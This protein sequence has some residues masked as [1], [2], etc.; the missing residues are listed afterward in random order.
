M[1]SRNN[2]EFTYI[3]TAVDTNGPSEISAKKASKA[4][5]YDFKFTYPDGST[6]TGT[7]A[8][9]GHYGYKV[10][11]IIDTAYGSYKITAKVGNTKEASGTVK[12]SS[13]YDASTGQSYTPYDTSHNLS[14]GS[15]GLGSEYDSI[16]G[17]NGTL[18]FGLGGQYEAPES[19][20]LY[21]FTFTYN[22][23]S[24]Y[25]GTVSS[26]ASNGTT[27]NY[28]G[29]IVPTSYGDY[30]IT[31]SV[32]ATAQTAGTVYVSSYYDVTSGQT[33]TPLDT[34]KGSSDGSYGLGYEGDYIY[35]VNGTG[36]SFSSNGHEATLGSTSF[37]YQFTYNDGSY[38][39]GTVTDNGSKG[40]YVGEVID[41]FASNGPLRGNYTITGSNGVSTDASG[42]VTI[43]S[44]Y[45][46]SSGE[47]FT[48]F[49][50]QY[51]GT[52]YA[53]GTS[54]LGSEYDYTAT[55][56]NG[57]KSFGGGGGDEAKQGVT[58]YDFT[59]TFS[60]GSYYSGTVADNGSYG[61]FVGE[62]YFT[63]YGYYEVTGSSGFSTSE[64]NGAVQVTSYYD[65]NSKKSYTPYYDWQG[66]ADGSSGLTSEYDST[67]GAS[68]SQSFGEGKYEAKQSTSTSGTPQA[69]LYDF[70]FFYNNGSYYTGTVADSGKYGYS[71][72]AA[73]F[74]SYGYYFITG[75][76]GS[77]SEA[78]GTVSVTSYWDKS[79]GTSYTPYDTWKGSSDGSSGLGSESDS[80]YG[81]SG[82]QNFGDGGKYEAV[83][84]PDTLYDYKFV[85]SDGSYY[86]GTV[87]DNG[88]YGYYVGDTID[89][90]NNGASAGYYEITGNAGDV[91]TSIGGF[92]LVG[93]VTI[94]SYYDT[95]S[96]QS[97]IP[98]VTASGWV[99]GYYGLGDESSSTYG[100]NGTQTFGKGGKYEA[101]QGGTVYDYTFYYTDGSY[102]SGTVV[103]DGAYGYYVGDTMQL[104]STGYYAITGS[105]GKTSTITNGTV[106][107]SSY[108]DSYSNSTYTPLETFEN[109]SDG[110]SGLNSEYDYI[111]NNG[112]S[113]NFGYGGKYEAKVTS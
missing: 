103:D 84:A 66:N 52:G 2:S 16:S 54:G 88:N 78:S 11:K 31:S 108:Y 101:K 39:T 111:Y 63:S 27:V 82:S 74:T 26:G 89:E 42:L 97:Y 40:Y 49:N 67:Y 92:N 94:S 12:V 34:Y 7:V 113:Y 21:N 79:T 45:D 102:Y 70:E 15:T 28:V 75:T 1:S 59:F 46:V 93:R 5:L 43:E 3:G 47:T 60:D 4:T 36:G 107:T 55:T 19:N 44:Y 99:A 73:Y 90:Y 106:T 81:A 9:N 62:S 69:T 95:S 110:S 48:P 17:A 72:G 41:E 6:Y 50:S 109:K 57:T 33:C 14:D 25:T 22:D 37:T 96:D 104:N 61:Y 112:N 20:I 29:Q 18:Y 100:A 86:T 24:F 80:T 68:G 77:T 85:Y 53:D 87:I 13:Y 83:Q 98:Y 56:T 105:S 38:Y 23:G 65:S 64:A 91:A 58:L 30:T 32:G 8:D 35:S 51:H 71:T 76:A 10:G